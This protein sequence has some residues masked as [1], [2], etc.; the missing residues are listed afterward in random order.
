MQTL[1]RIVEISSGSI[2][3]D[4]LDIAKLGLRDL[5]EKLAIIPQVSLAVFK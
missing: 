1:F 4:G 3:V 5:R 2:K